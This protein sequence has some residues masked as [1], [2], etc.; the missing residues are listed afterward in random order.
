MSL[1]LWSLLQRLCRLT[2]MLQ[3]APEPSVFFSLSLLASLDYTCLYNCFAFKK[4]GI[5]LPVSLLPIDFIQNILT[6]LVTNERMNLWMKLKESKRFN[7]IE[8]SRIRCQKTH[9]DKDL[10][11]VHHK[12]T[13]DPW[14]AYRF[15]AC[16]WSRAWSW[17]PG[18]ESQIRLLAWSLLLPLPA[19]LPLFLS[20]CV[21][22][23]NK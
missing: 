2:K 17:S 4:T 9:P 22:I 3:H 8:Q 10:C 14:V 1:P 5:L 13:R 12:I 18:V 21:S 7:E 20:L 23:M 15:G 16:L 11:S 6:P 19:S